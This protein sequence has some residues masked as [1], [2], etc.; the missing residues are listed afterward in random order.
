MSEPQPTDSFAGDPPPMADPSPRAVSPEPVEEAG[1]TADVG[2]ASRM[3]KRKALKKLKRKQTRREAAI[4]EREE[5]EARSNDPEEQ[6]K[7]RL[8]EQE[9]V[10]I[11]E[12]ERKQFE[13]RER[14]WLEAAAARK[15]AEEDEEQRRKELM[16]KS[17]EKNQHD[18]HVNE[19]DGDD[20]WDYI[21]EGPA[22]IIWQGNEIIV[23]KKRVRVAKKNA[24]KQQSEEDDNR[25]TS[26][27]L[28]PQSVVFASYMNGPSIS[29]QEVLERV[30]QEVP[31]F[32]TEQD[33]AHC[34]FHLKTGA[35]RFGPR[36]SRV[37]FHPDKS[38]TLLIKNMY[39][40]P[41]LVSEQ[42]EGLE[43]PDEEVERCYEEFY[44]DVHTEFLKFGELVNFKVCK[45]GSYHLRGNVYV[46][47]KSLDSAVLAYNNINGRF[48]AG[49]Q[50]TCEFVGVT[51][52][53]VAICGEYMKSKLKTCSHGS[54]CNFIHCFRNPGGDYEWADWDN[55]PPKY[56]IRKMIALFG[57][58]NEYEHDK[59]VD[60]KEFDRPS[61]HRSRRSDSELDELNND[62]PAKN[63]REQSSRG[64]EKPTFVEKHERSEEYDK[65]DEKHRS[66]CYDSGKDIY[67]ENDKDFLKKHQKYEENYY[68]DRESYKG[69]CR[70]DS[71]GRKRVKSYVNE[72][73]KSKRYKSRFQEQQKYAQFSDYTDD[74]RE[75]SDGH[76]NSLSSDKS[77][78]RLSIDEERYNGRSCS[79]DLGSDIDP[80]HRITSQHSGC[81]TKSREYG[82]RSK[83]K[84]Y[85]FE[86]DGHS[87]KFGKPNDHHLK[88]SSHD[89]DWKAR[90]EGSDIEDAD[91]R[92]PHSRS[93]RDKKHDRSSR[94]R[95]LHPK[96]D[97]DNDCSKPSNL[98]SS[99]K[100][101]KGEEEKRYSS[102][103]RLYRKDTPK[104][105][106]VRPLL[107][108]T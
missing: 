100:K 15:A 71:L 19:V 47:Y 88:V 68:D 102:V 42:D 31:N 3:E 59:Q 2:C 33:K 87:S 75:L 108:K 60:L 72:H 43:Y 7:I 34:P 8:R 45:N 58:S 99:N 32:G 78:H 73:M 30:A 90:S 89:L 65:F 101:L 92:L 61:R 24:N 93:S 10:E 36:C 55:P 49:K 52:W 53:K 46:H 83:H 104:Q 38:C 96:K 35:C 11:A 84:S 17:Q 63:R 107:V 54:A 37:H 56:W 62:S 74:D 82:R 51:K 98:E 69:K 5:D 22:E 1:A 14:M 50:I 41:G 76:S 77:S 26:N 28:P 105:R 81:L 25:P 29:A 86:I 12:R 91:A 67:K 97:E 95:N 6:R 94:K 64:K 40:G 48:F 13:E 70:E 39:N 106:F 103:E 66:H 79:D 18:A 57:P 85:D 21:E 23:K 20:E 4:R 44:E 9:E 80:S 27:P 16:D